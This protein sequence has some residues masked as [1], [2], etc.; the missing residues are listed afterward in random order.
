MTPKTPSF[1]ESIEFAML[2]CNDWEE[3]DLSD[4]VLADRV[5][6][7]IRTSNGARGFFVV[8]LATNSPILD[9][10]PEA[11]LKQLRIAGENVVDLTTKNLAMSSAMAIHHKRRKDKEQKEGSERVSSRCIDLLK[12]LETT[13]VKNRLEKFLSSIENRE[14]EDFNFIKRWEYDQE[15]ITAISININAI[16]QN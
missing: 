10:L 14:G 8:G 1:E 6:E 2:W 5:A 12:V 4:E 16:A 3:G 13:L 7:L 15:Q 11:L 9:R